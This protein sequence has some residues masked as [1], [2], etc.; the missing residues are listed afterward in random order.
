M[1]V[2]R[3]IALDP[4]FKGFG[5]GAGFIMAIGAQNAFVLR[6]GIRRSHV[7]ATALICT[8]CDVALIALGVGGLGTLI[9]GDTVLKMVATWGGFTFLLLYGLLSFKA[10]FAAKKD[11]QPE[12]H[13]KSKSLSGTVLSALGISLLNPHVY[14]DTVVLIGSVG[15]QFPPGERIMFASGAVLASSVWFFCLAYGAVRLSPV[16]QRP[17]SWRIL[18]LITGCIMLAVAVSLI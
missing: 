3:E 8:L 7:F 18:N 17:L 9:A 16:F 15:A 6:Q 4:L 5:L 10:A 2:I 1:D 13:F 12:I 14:L 11:S